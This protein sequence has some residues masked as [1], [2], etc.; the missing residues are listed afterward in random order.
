M[1]VGHHLTTFLGL[2]YSPNKRPFVYRHERVLIKSMIS[3]SIGFL[4]KHG[5]CYLLI[6][7]KQT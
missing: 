4:A 5:V 1:L 7:G 3:L 2:S 6:F